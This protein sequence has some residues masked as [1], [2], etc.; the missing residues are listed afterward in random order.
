MLH[1]GVLCIEICL[2]Q[3]PSWSW[4]IY[5]LSGNF[6]GI[7]LCFS[8]KSEVYEAM[9]NGLKFLLALFENCLPDLNST[10]ALVRFATV[11]FLIMC[12]AAN[13]RISSGRR[14]PASLDAPRVFVSTGI[15]RASLIA[16]LSRLCNCFRQ[17][18][19]TVK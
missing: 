1:F 19:G 6:P 5:H 3:F 7:H 13:F 17:L 16:S 12:L 18:F 10:S 11:E 9:V 8:N 2:H 14:M 4:R 15:P